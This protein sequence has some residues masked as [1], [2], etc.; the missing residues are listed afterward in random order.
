MKA[1]VGSFLIAGGTAAASAHVP[2]AVFVV[3]GL[4]LN[5]AVI[6]VLNSVRLVLDPYFSGGIAIALVTFWNYAA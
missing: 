2:Y 3:P 5:L 6:A 1:E 4:V